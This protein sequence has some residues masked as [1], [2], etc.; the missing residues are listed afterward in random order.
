MQRRAL[1]CVADAASLQHTDDTASGSA[2]ELLAEVGRCYA[3]YTG[4]VAGVKDPQEFQHLKGTVRE[5]E[6]DL[7]WGYHGFTPSKHVEH[8]RM[9]FYKGDTFSEEPQMSRD[10]QPLMQLLTS[11][12]PDVVTVALDPEGS[13]PDTHYKVLQAVAAAV[14]GVTEGPA[15][16]VSKKN[17]GY[18]DTGMSGSASIHL[19]ARSW[20]L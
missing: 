12:S 2:N 4:Q 14:K 1:R 8:L 16:T 7:V 18:S 13:G 20:C 17:S 11:Q 19:T 5:L 15:A 6:G 3:Y 10:V 9:G